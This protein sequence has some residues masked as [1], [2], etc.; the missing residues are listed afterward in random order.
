MAR[1]PLTNRPGGPARRTGGREVKVDIR[2]RLLPLPHFGCFVHGAE[3]VGV[4][5]TTDRER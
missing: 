4:D 1:V 5:W 3:V 2:I